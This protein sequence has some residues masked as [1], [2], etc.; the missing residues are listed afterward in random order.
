MAKSGRES[1]I[2]FVWATR[3]RSWG[4]RFLRQADLR[5]PLPTYERAFA[6]FEASPEV[7]RRLRGAIVA[8]RFADPEGRCDEAGRIIPHD[9]VLLGRW[10]DTIDSLEAGRNRIWPLVAD[11]YDAWWDQPA[12]PRV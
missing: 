11:E 4:F 5:D 7:F 2:A 10:A 6:G 3:G 12:P 9:F 1:P 8:V